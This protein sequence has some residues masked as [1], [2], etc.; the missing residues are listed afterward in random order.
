ARIRRCCLRRRCLWLIPSSSQL[1]VSWPARQP[2]RPNAWV[3]TPLGEHE[4]V[5]VH[6]L[7]G[8]MRE[9]LADPVAPHAL[10]PA[11]LVRRVVD[12]PLADG[13]AVGG[14]LDGVAGLELAL[15]LG[16]ADRQQAAPPLPPTPP[17][18]PLP[19]NLPTPHL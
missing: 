1:Q 17:S 9:K 7:L 8:R 4:V 3:S 15:D 18:P 6:G 14:D 12:D 16:D 19:P 2:I 11:E 5:P 13:P 10:D